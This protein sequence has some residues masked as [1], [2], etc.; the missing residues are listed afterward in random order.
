MWRDFLLYQVAAGLPPSQVHIELLLSF[1]ESL[2]QNGHSK[3]SIDNYMA[4]TRAMHIVHGLPTDPFRDQRISFY[5]K[6][7]KISA[8]FSPSTRP[9]LDI[10]TLNALLSFC[11]SVPHPLVFKAL[12]SVAFFSFLRLSKLLPHSLATYNCTRQLARGDFI[13]TGS[14]AVLLLKW[15]KTIQDRKLVLTIPLRDLCQSIL[16]PIG[17]LKAMIHAFP[18][19]SHDPLFDIPKN[20]HLVPLRDSVARK[21]LKRASLALN[22][23]PPLTFHAFRRAGTS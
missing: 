16:C 20:N 12:Y 21:H 13:I 2:H 5:L 9:S 8:P 17:A 14:N 3:S 1:I 11:E 6:A 15:S 10:S 7:L 18:A 4:A 23:T 22:I 19:S